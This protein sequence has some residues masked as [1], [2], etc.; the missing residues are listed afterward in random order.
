MNRASLK[1]KVEQEVLVQA[2]AFSEWK[3]EDR[4]YTFEEMEVKALEIAKKMA[5][6]LLNYGVADEQQVER[7]QRP[8]VEPSCPG[9]GRPMRYGGQPD[10]TLDS[11]AGEIRLKR[12]YY[13]C[14]GCK[15]GLFPPGPTAGSGGG[16]VE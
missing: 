8:E 9:C 13:H 6:A 4:V 11:K 14:P 5:Q 1:E 2:Q 12:D 10:K 15:A 16:E 3:R 7:Q